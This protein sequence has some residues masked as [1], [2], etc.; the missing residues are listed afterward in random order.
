[1]PAATQP[2]GETPASTQEEAPA[3]RP[4]TV[5][6]QLVPTG[7]VSVCLV[8][9][10]GRVLIANEILQ[11]GASTETFRSR[12]FRMVLGNNA[13][14]LRVNGKNRTVPPS[15]VPIA[16]ELTPNGRKTITG[17]RQPTCT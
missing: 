6:L 7:P 14:R 1:M 13:V 9:A 5:R 15:S 17:D 12:R 4:R 8:D 11:A 3:P 2:G 16:Y 10:R